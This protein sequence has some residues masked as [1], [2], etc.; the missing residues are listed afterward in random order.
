MESNEFVPEE[1]PQALKVLCVLTFIYTSFMGIFSLMGLIFAKPFFS[2]MN[3]IYA[4][5]ENNPDVKE[6]QLAQL[7]KILEM[8][9]GKFAV[10][11]GIFLLIIGASFYGTVQMWQMRY[12]GFVFYAVAN[13]ML[14][15]SN[16]VQL[17]IFGIVVDVLFLSLYYFQSKNLKR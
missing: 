4:Q 5:M 9:V 2:F 13:A 17:N 12:K 16:A 1:K 7:R 6:E 8:G 14:L 3:N 10:M 15:V 11:C